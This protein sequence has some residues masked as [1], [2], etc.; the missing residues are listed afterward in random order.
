MPGIRWWSA[1]GP[2]ACPLAGRPFRLLRSR[3]EEPYGAGRAA[4]RPHPYGPPL[5]TASTTPGRA[6]RGSDLGS[7]PP[8][9]LRAAPRAPR[10]P[11][12]MSDDDME[13]E[14]PP[15]QPHARCAPASG[16]QTAARAR[17]APLRRDLAP[18]RCC[19]RRRA[20]A[21]P[22]RWHAP[23]TD[24]GF[25]YSDEEQEEEDVDIENQYYNSKGARG[26]GRPLLL[27]R[28]C[29]AAV[30]CVFFPCTSACCQCCRMLPHTAYAVL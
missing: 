6:S 10:P 29:N 15:R 25:E 2:G 24:Y 19:R 16:R 14:P 8:A 7:A 3:W 5:D 28:A 30:V 26:K 23:L 20:H 13:G 4:A 21:A 18:T 11:A 22:N 17:A 1:T 9:G 27:R 12:A